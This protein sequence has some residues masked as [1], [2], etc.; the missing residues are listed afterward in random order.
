VE[1]QEET[2]ND[3]VGVEG[4]DV[5]LLDDDRIA[6]DLEQLLNSM[7]THYFVGTTMPL[8]VQEGDVKG[9]NFEANPSSSTHFLQLPTSSKKIRP[10]KYNTNAVVDFSKSLLVTSDDYIARVQQV[11]A[12]NE[13]RAREK[14]ARQISHDATK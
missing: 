12:K 10:T 11:Q 8:A 6:E 14:E 9:H 1:V 13:Q 2:R 4:E 7:T 5:P 3:E